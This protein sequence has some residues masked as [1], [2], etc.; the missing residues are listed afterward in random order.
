MLGKFRTARCGLRMLCPGSVHL[1]GSFSCM[2]STGESRE[3]SKPSPGLHVERERPAAR[4]AR[5]WLDLPA[6]SDSA[7]ESAKRESERERSYRCLCRN[8]WEVQRLCDLP[9]RLSHARAQCVRKASGLWGATSMPSCLQFASRLACKRLPGPLFGALKHRPCLER[10]GV[11]MA[12][13]ARQRAHTKQAA[14]E[15]LTVLLE[16]GGRAGKS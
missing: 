12:S 4:L 8:S 6:R 11:L 14:V 5:G 2:C 15:P 1:D 7:R 10:M 3:R 13:S 16:S 9:G